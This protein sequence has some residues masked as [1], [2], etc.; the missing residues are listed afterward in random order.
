MIE[1]AHGK[2]GLSQFPVGHIAVGMEPLVLSR[3]HTWEVDR[4]FGSPVMS[5]QIAQVI[6][7]HGDVG[8]PLLLQSYEYSHADG[9]HPSLPHTVEAIQ[10]PFKL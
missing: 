3:P 4:V 10:T 6:C 7:H 5:L 9:V 8:S 2:R 1:D